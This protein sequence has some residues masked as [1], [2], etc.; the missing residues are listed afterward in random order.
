[1]R[2]LTFGDFSLDETRM[3]LRKG[4]LR[5]PVQAKVLLALYQLAAKQGRVVT[6]EELMRSVWP[7][8]TVTQASI[9]RAIN[10][11]RQA[12]GDDGDSQRSIRT[13][14]GQGYQLVIPVS[15][16][17]SGGR[18]DDPPSTA[19]GVGFDRPE[20]LPSRPNFVGRQGILDLLDGRL[21]E[22]LSGRPQCVLLIGEPGIGKTTTLAEFARRVS[23]AGADAW[24]GRCLGDEGAPAFWPWTQI[25]RACS[26]S[27]GQ[28]ELR[29]L[30]GV[31]AGD[32]L[33]GLPAASQ[34]VGEVTEAPT[35]DQASARFRFFDAIT[36]FLTR[37]AESKPIVLLFDD[38]H[39][40][41]QPSLR[42]LSFVTRSIDASRLMI[43]LSMRPAASQAPGVQELLAE[44]LRDISANC[45]ELPAFEPDDVKRMLEL[46][47]GQSAP[48]A[49][50][51]K[52]HHLTGGSPLFLQH[53]LHGW[54]TTKRLEQAG[55]WHALL[56]P[57][58]G[59]SLSGA[60]AR[61]LG[62]LHSSTRRWLSLASVL[63]TEFTLNRLATLSGE[64]TSSLLSGL[65]AAKAAGVVR[66]AP[67]GSGTY[68]FTHLLV[69]EVLYSALPPD[70]RSSLHAKVGA[71]LEAYQAPS[72]AVL[73]ELAHHFGLAW[74]A[75]DDGRALKYT[76]RSA[77]TAEKRLAYEEAAALY[78]RALHISGASDAPDALV[79]LR[80]LFKKGEAL[81]HA[82]EA[83]GA[84]SVLLMAVELAREL[85]AWDVFAD[86][87][88]LIAQEPEVC[89]L[90][91]EKVSLLREA[92]RV[93]PENDPRRPLH[94]ALLA[95][96][97]TYALERPGERTS[98]ALQSIED[99][100][101]L[102]D[103]VARANVWHQCQLALAE[104]IHLTT[105]ERIAGELAHLGQI[106]GDH[107]VVW[108]WATAHLQ[109]ALERGDFGGVD[110]AI[111]AIEGLANQAR[112]PLYRWH[113][114]LF[115]GMRC[116]VAG[117]IREAERFAIEALHRGACV[118]ESSAHNAYCMQV[119]GWLRIMNRGAECEALARNMHL[120]YPTFTGWR[121]QLAGAEAD[122]GQ[123]QFARQSMKEIFDEPR[124]MHDPFT[125]GM[126]CA[127]SELCSYFGTEEMAR[128][129]HTAMLPHALLWGNSGFGLNTFGP[130]QRNLG[131]L[132]TR[133]GDLD[134]ADFHFE[135]ALTLTEEARSLTFTSLTCLAYARAQLKRGGP[136]HTR[137]AADLLAH[138]DF[139]N[140]TCRFDGLS[141]VVRMIAERAQLRLPLP[142]VQELPRDERL[143][144]DA[145]WRRFA[146]LPGRSEAAK[147][148]PSDEIEGQF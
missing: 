139:L 87:A 40:A 108:H 104:P 123:S 89:D 107:R 22:A 140:Q 127:V 56:T 41:D 75:H 14:R 2:I 118:G 52:L 26:I 113:L 43:A 131:M 111:A 134:A 8:E 147:L 47:T 115:R 130:V 70:E 66:A 110:R 63:G 106:H 68:A 72:D 9:K 93:L 114:A 55:D 94:T 96:S 69:R 45:M 54:Q 62:D 91:E 137:R 138:S 34:W 64:N 21:R 3:E 17:E 35:I 92:L 144:S 76:V 97:L 117:D 50:V 25:I 11:A 116:Y 32:I 148:R 24:S 95:K 1:M 86:A 28:G 49:F 129:L 100:K 99:A 44:L 145:V 136:T 126:Q 98:L 74:P 88:S 39:R 102:D 15:V 61:V 141:V 46:R 103:P 78:D 71:S 6:H 7:N 37:A 146:T 122:R 48:D 4:T 121:I 77:E 135:R 16:S 143:G 80:F 59:R 79:R 23:E 31:H 18:A 13:V 124:L 20:T 142:P 65:T 29:R 60:I 5:V 109:N 57:S 90:D 30:M 12:L 82:A 119:C 112:E 73:A 85:R 51:K 19:D 58:D 120:R 42:L 10:G 128:G 38:L 101:R 81:N 105:R 33:Q 133:M 132:A 53:V 84:R 36:L 27:R 83:E 125:L 67:P